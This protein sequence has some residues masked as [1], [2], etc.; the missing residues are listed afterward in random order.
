MVWWIH[1]FLLWLTWCHAHQ[2]PILKQEKVNSFHSFQSL[3]INLCTF[4]TK[5]STYRGI[6]HNQYNKKGNGIHT[7]T[8][9][10]SSAATQ[11][12]H[13]RDND[14][15]HAESITF[16]PQYYSGMW[17]ISKI[18]LIL[19]AHWWYNNSM[20]LQWQQLGKVIFWF[21]SRSI[22]FKK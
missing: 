6:Q 4:L 22:V 1:L 14:K 13:S 19:T 3:S 20:P 2:W 21:V 15:S 7:W 12:L 17:I 9:L 16:S 8:R 18:K 11:S 10:T 5:N